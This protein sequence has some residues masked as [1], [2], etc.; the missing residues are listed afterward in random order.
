[1]DGEFDA[2]DIDRE[3]ISARLKQDVLDN[4]GKVHLFVADS[5]RDILFHAV[6]C[7][8][9]KDLPLSS[10]ISLSLQVLCFVH[11]DIVSL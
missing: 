10:L 5:V 1:M 7:P 11:V 9:L 4:S 8:L 6:P 2:A 3:L